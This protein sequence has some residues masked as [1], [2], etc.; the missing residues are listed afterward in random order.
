MFACNLHIF[1]ETWINVDAV[2]LRNAEN[3]NEQLGCFK[4]NKYY[5]ETYN[6]KETEISGTQ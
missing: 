3:T 2:L 5:K 4:E 1:I 6:Q